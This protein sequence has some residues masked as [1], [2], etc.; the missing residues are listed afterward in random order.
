M[1]EALYLEWPE[2][3]LTDAVAILYPSRTKKQKRRIVKLP[4]RAI[5]A[6]ANLSDRE[7]AVFRRPDGHPYEP[8]DGEGGQCK[9]AWHG[10]LRRAGFDEDFLGLHEYGRHTWASWHYAV[11]KDLLL[12]KH[13]GGWAS[14]KEVERYAHLVETSQVPLITRFWGHEAV[15][16]LVVGQL[17]G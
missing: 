8:K 4:P 17:S 2:V 12:L 15:T 13:E 14:V 11:H 6:L 7:G 3:N 10:A 5:A 9:T 16:G 1:S